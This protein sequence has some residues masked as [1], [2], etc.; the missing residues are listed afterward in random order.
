MALNSLQ[1]YDEVTGIL[2]ISAYIILYWNDEIRIW[3]TT[4]YNGLD[5]I[6]L[7]VQNT[8]IPKIIIRNMVIQKTFFYYSKS[9]AIN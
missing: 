5:L 9:S 3:N 7:P 4:D 2:K 1:D 6:Q 8:W